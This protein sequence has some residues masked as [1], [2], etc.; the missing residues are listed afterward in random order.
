MFFQFPFSLQWVEQFVFSIF[1][2]FAMIELLLFPSNLC[3]FCNGQTN[4]I[5]F[6]IVFY[7]KIG[8]QFLFFQ[9]AFFVN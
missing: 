5:L 2:P 4:F 8:K 1:F 7:F 6:S 3:Q 9:I